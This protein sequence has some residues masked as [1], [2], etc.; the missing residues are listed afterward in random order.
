MAEQTPPSEPVKSESDLVKLIE[1]AI[2]A[3]LT[4]PRAKV[5]ADPSLSMR[6]LAIDLRKKL[7]P[8][9]VELEALQTAV[10]GLSDVFSDQEFPVFPDAG[11]GHVLETCIHSMQAKLE[12]LQETFDPLGPVRTYGQEPLHHIKELAREV[13]DVTGIVCGGHPRKVGALMLIAA[14]VPELVKHI[15]EFELARVQ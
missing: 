7:I 8:Q 1:M 2:D 3:L 14:A 5:P 6:Q 12:R 10:I 9:V 15:E 11:L 4:T 13:Q